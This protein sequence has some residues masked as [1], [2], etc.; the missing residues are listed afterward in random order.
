M[1][2]NSG[3]EFSGKEVV[4][5][6]AAFLQGERPREYKRFLGFQ[7]TGLLKPGEEERITISCPV[8]YL[9]SY[10]EESASWVI[11]EGTYQL[12]LGNSGADGKPVGKLRVE[13]PLT[14]ERVSA[15]C[16]LQEELQEIRPDSGDA[17]ADARLEEMFLS[18]CG[19][20]YSDQSENDTAPLAEGMK[21]EEMLWLICGNAGT[22]S[23]SD[24]GDD[25]GVVPGA[26]GE[27]TGRLWKKYGIPA[28]VLADGPAGLR[29][30][31][32]YQ[33]KESGEI[34]SQDIM[35]SLERGL[36]A[37]NKW[38]PDAAFCY[39]FCTAIP[40]AHALAQ[41]FNPELVE[42]VGR[43]VSEEMEEFGVN[44]WLAPGMNIHRNPLG[45]RN[46]EYYSEDPVLTGKI[47]SAMIRGVQ[48]RK[49]CGAVVKHFACNNREDNRK[50][51]DSIVSERALREIYLKG[52][53][54]AITEAK[55]AGVMSAYNLVNGIHA[56]NNYDLCTK[57]L[58]EE[59][60]YDGIVMTDWNSTTT[61][62]AD[63]A[64]CVRAGNDLI[65]PGAEE[66]LIRLK[67]AVREGTVSEKEVAICAGRLIGCIRRLKG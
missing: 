26:A 21:L 65:M 49:G 46:F 67:E 13:Q 56:A 28:V 59:W 37:E 16:P 14:I 44:L 7:K 33:I 9:E 1:V 66:D 43:A 15:V 4:Q 12:L 23:K 17:Y 52:F 19:P 2:K 53:Q 57:I 60:H 58:R 10:V 39:Q 35:A 47:A 64:L 32:Q 31:Q 51:L 45:G 40:V 20:R 38:L 55:P 3:T 5:L 25:G 30:C 24:L 29:L 27:T 42:R 8:S 11:E 41:T 34:Y 62:G 22:G 50:F 6:Y 36:F 18:G 48:S 63:A 54:I 61:G